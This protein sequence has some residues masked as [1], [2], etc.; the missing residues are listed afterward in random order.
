MTNRDECRVVRNFSSTIARR[1]VSETQGPSEAAPRQFR[2]DA[3]VSWRSGG[4]TAGPTVA[5][6]CVFS[7]ICTIGVIF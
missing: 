5:Q 2:L 1:L 6:Q 7:R 4:A 3:L